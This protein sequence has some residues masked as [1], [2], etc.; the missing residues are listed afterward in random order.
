MHID[1]LV[2]YDEYKMPKDSHFM[3]NQD[4]K[5][6][7]GWNKSIHSSPNIPIVDLVSKIVKAMLIK[8]FK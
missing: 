2:Q 1:N 4:E 3:D 7:D 5:D 8:N 6:D